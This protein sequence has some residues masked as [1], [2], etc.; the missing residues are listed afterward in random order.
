MKNEE[1][2]TI[3]LQELRNKVRLHDDYLMGS[4]YPV[5]SLVCLENTHNLCSGAV[6][7]PT[8][9]KQVSCIVK[10]FNMKLHFDGARIFNAAVA[11]GKP[12]DE[13]VRDVDSVSV[14]LS[15]GLCCP[16]GTLLL[17]D[18]DFILKAHRVRKAIGGGLRQSGYMAAT[19]IYALKNLVNR[20]ADDH[21]FAYKIAS[22]IH[23]QE[24]KFVKGKL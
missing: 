24:S 12:V 1:N 14:C 2:G 7:Q 5:S 17:G 16:M 18:R 4:L 10:E 23:R 13:I 21:E 15:K 19:G 11:L 22:A 3:D 9:V 6:L 8:Y 20:L